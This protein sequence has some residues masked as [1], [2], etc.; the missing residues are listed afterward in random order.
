MA[1]QKTYHDELTTK[2]DAARGEDT[3]KKR[4]MLYLD[5]ALYDRVKAFCEA[6]KLS[7]NKASIIA[8]ETM[9]DHVE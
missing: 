5:P 6:R 3:E 2:L 9:L 4:L 8:L 1:K 7:M